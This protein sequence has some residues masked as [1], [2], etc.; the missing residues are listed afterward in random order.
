M[1]HLAHLFANPSL[2]RNALEISPYAV[3]VTTDSGTVLFANQNTTKWF[4]FGA[5][6][7]TGMPLEGLL[8][9]VARCDRDAQGVLTVAQSVS[10]CHTLPAQNVICKDGTPIPVR[11]D[12][13]PVHQDSQTLLMASIQCDQTRS[14]PLPDL[15]SERLDAIATMI[16]GLAHESRNALQRAVACLDL[17]DLD[18]NDPRQLDLSD[19]IRRS[20]SDLLE[21]YDEVRRFAQPITLNRHPQ[22]IAAICLDAW[23]E[24][25][26]MQPRSDADLKIIDSTDG[27]PVAIV[28]AEKMK[29]V[30][31]HLIENALEE[32]YSRLA[33]C[34]EIR[35]V[36]VDDRDAVVIG[37]HND[38]SPFHL[39]ALRRAFEP[40]YSTKP[41]GSG[42]G[43]AICS[44]IVQSHGGKIRVRNPDI[45]GALVEILLPN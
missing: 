14:G 18:L 13:I 39:H 42:L 8:P 36:A 4:G 44:R 10:I 19:R 30:F 26:E 28:D 23:R 34:I 37:V 27:E 25:N 29:E 24:L 41:Q 15:E 6:E 45:G 5:E 35:R 11:I 3:L 17:L 2:T 21:N 31:V 9:L 33:I 12:L 40:F 20:L 22:P 1:N 32:P 16:S 38:G 7:L 43:L